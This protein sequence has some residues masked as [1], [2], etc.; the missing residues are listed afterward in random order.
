VV[1][2]AKMF[3]A[4][5]G[6]HWPIVNAVQP[7]PDGVEGRSVEGR[8]GLRVAVPFKERPRMTDFAASRCWEKRSGG[9]S[10]LN[11]SGEHRVLALA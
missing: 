5:D 11:A 3:G 2:L 9:K 10:R 8:T 1:D 6:L 4:N 7:D